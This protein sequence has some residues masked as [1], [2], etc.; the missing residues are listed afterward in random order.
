MADGLMSKVGGWFRRGNRAAADAAEPTTELV[1]AD[2]RPSL[3]RPFAKRD[4]A[5]QNLQ[6]GFESFNGL[7]S[8]INT[9]LQAQGRRQA[10]STSSP[11]RRART[12]DGA[13]PSAP[14]A[15]DP[16]N[17][18]PRQG[19]PAHPRAGCNTAPGPSTDSWRWWNWA[20]KTR[21]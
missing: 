18:T 11:Q 7:V 15:W 19:S 14:P 21:V 20:A 4:N 17:T 13:L 8:T 1:Q 3:L 16:G 9:N 6:K 5:L 2:D 10:S 12:P